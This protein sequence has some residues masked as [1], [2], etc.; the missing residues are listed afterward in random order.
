VTGPEPS[1]SI[2]IASPP[3]AG[4]RLFG[5]ILAA[6]LLSLIVIIP[7]GIWIVR[8][9]S[10]C[11]DDTYHLYRGLELLRGDWVALN[12]IFLNDPPFGEAISA[13]PAYFNGVHLQDNIKVYQLR[14]DIPPPPENCYTM[15]DWL[16]IETLAWKAILFLPAVAILFSWVAGVYGRRAA[17]LALG[18]VLVEP[19]FAAHLPLPTVDVI[20]VEGILI[21][22]WA[23]WRFIV[24]PTGG[25]LIACGVTMGL[26]MSIKH[27]ALMLP[28]LA[29]LLAFIHW[30]GRG[31]LWRKP[32][33]LAGNIG[34]SA[35]VALVAA[36]TIWALCGFNFTQPRE[37]PLGITV[38]GE[39]TLDQF[40]LPAGIYVKSVFYAIAHSI[41]GQPNY[42]WGKVSWHGWWYYFPVVATY[43]IP[44]G[45]GFIL[46]MGVA[47]LLW[48]RPRYDEVPLFACAMVWTASLMNQSVDI[49]FRHFLPAEMFLLMLAS[50]CVARPVTLANLL[51]WVALA[52]AAVE[53][54]A[55]SPNYM[56]YINFPRQDIWLQI[57]DSNL[58]W[59]QGRKMLRRWIDGLPDD[60]RPLYYGYF[61]P[62]DVKLYDQLGPRLTEYTSCGHWVRRANLPENAANLVPDVAGSMPDHGRLVISAVALTGQYDSKTDHFAE[63]REAHVEP[64][65]TLGNYLL[66]YDLD[67]LRDEGRIK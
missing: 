62:M 40:T 9:H 50:R 27:T 29:I 7:R 53:V 65:Q 43:K 32:A 28:V 41:Q 39:R 51:A 57:S 12:N 63:L 42:L 59:G 37:N 38:P 36:V 24:R 35:V 8:Q 44:L 46:L 25:R 56:S 52:V 49:G 16:R 21:A 13:L 60:G 48:V 2:E 54:A 19:T 61:G 10:T 4:T 6:M 67:R 58:D 18:M 15:P 17:W 33:E 5:H 26:A 11:V 14:Q 23:L 31:K 45:I 30:V 47:S 64:E 34:R 3:A 20:G 22:S 1:S 66:I 55:R